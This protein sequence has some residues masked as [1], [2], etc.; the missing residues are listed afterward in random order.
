M[1]FMSAGSADIDMIA[2]LTCP[3]LLYISHHRML[4]WG[5]SMRIAKII[6]VSL[7]NIG[8]LQFWP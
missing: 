2:E 1:F 6:P 4:L 5:K 8:N 7:E 3:A